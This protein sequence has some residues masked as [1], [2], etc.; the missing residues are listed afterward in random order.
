[1]SLQIQKHVIL[2]MQKMTSCLP[3]VLWFLILTNLLYIQRRGFQNVWTT[4]ISDLI[5]IESLLFLNN[6]RM[7][8]LYLRSKRCVSCVFVVFGYCI[9]M[10]SLRIPKHFADFF[11]QADYNFFR[12][13]F[14]ALL[15][16]LVIK[17]R[18]IPQIRNGNNSS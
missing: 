7:L 11:S 3:K 13:I 9:Y 4:I 8:C 15:N 16:L 14:L 1:M 18:L 6:K 17:F 2:E 12:F 5:E 10:L